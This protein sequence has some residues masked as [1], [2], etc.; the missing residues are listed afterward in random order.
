ME[1]PQDIDGLSSPPKGFKH[2]I[3]TQKNGTEWMKTI[4]H[5]N[6][7]AI[8]GIQV[9]HEAQSDIG[10]KMIVRFFYN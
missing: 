9:F 4:V 6:Y 5:A 8:T 10:G 7:P 2:Y 3:D 1:V